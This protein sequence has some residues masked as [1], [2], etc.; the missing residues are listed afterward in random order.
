MLTKRDMLKGTAAIGLAALAGRI[1]PSLAQEIANIQVLIPAAPGGGWDQTGRTMVEV[2]KTEK[3][4]G[5][6]QVTNVAGAGGTVALPQFVNQWRGRTNAVMVSGLVMDGAI[7]LNKSQSKLTQTVPLMRLTGE[8]VAVVVGADSPIKSMRE[9][10]DMLKADAKKVSVAGGSAGSVDHI[11][12]GMIGKAVGAKV[13]ELNYVAYSGGGPAN[14]AIIG[15]HVTAG[16]SGVNEVAEHVKAGKMRLLAVSAPQ[17]LA[18][19]DGPTLK[20]AGLDLE[21]A[22]WRGVFAPPGTSDEHRKALIAFFEK[23]VATPTWKQEVQ[24][25]DWTSIPLSGD[26]FAKYVEAESA[27]IETILKEIGLVT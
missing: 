15:G 22:N 3:L 14:A 16:M 2:L 7:V 18:G 17:R 4:I 20:E 24:K 23:M 25:R 8:Y 5:N 9:L 21:L 10:A 26:A 13:Q 1:D 27:R 19:L 11:L 12:L 6:A